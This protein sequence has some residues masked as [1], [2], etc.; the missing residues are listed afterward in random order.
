M[1]S[2]L[3]D[4]YR[5]QITI[6]LQEVVSPEAAILVAKAWLRN[7]RSLDPETRISLLRNNDRS[8]G[9]L[10]L[11]RTGQHLQG[12]KATLSELDISI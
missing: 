12:R 5:L 11:P 9:N 3:M 7:L 1:E 2:I 4:S 6:E 10:L 8:G